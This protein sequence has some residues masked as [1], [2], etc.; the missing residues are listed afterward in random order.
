MQRNESGDS[1][2]TVNG[3]QKY[4][5]VTDDSGPFVEFNFAIGDPTLF[6]ELVLPQEAFRHFCKINQV[7]MMTDHEME[8]IDKDA[9]KWRFGDETLIALNKRK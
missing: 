2:H 6:V 5:G 4:V 7:R 8:M 9:E 1:N 3:M